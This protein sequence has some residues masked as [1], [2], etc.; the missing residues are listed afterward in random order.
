[1]LVA[2]TAQ[3]D[4]N[5][6][7]EIEVLGGDE[8]GSLQPFIGMCYSLCAFPTRLHPHSDLSLCRALSG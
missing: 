7:V 3:F 2:N 8:Q 1:M 6:A 4:L 5:H